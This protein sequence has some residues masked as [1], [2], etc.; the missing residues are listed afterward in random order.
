MND[1]LALGASILEVLDGPWE[2]LDRVHP[3]LDARAQLIQAVSW[4]TDP[5][6]A[7][8]LEQ[9]ALLTQR[10]SAVLSH[11]RQRQRW[12]AEPRPSGAKFFDLRS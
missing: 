2:Q 7:E 6:S 9:D 8:L 4:S 1:L 3:L 10:C 12:Q 11:L 5:A